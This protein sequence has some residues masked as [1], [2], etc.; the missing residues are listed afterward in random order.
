[1]KFTTA[2]F[3]FSVLDF[4]LIRL[5]CYLMAGDLRLVKHT[6][7]SYNLV[8]HV[9]KKRMQGFN[10]RKLRCKFCVVICSSCR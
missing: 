6:R 7:N 2:A 3:S 10:T 5:I 4:I 9:S 8:F 1:M